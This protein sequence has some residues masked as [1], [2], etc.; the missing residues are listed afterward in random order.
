MIS[1]TFVFVCAHVWGGAG[2]GC[3][4]WAG[5]QGTVNMV[6]AASCVSFS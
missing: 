1:E 4:G 5:G 6:V 3:W 2:S